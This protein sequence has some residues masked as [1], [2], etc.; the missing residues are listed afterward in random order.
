MRTPALWLALSAFLKGQC[1]L[2]EAAPVAA[3]APSGAARQLKQGVIRDVSEAD[4]ATWFGGALLKPPP[5]RRPLALRG[6][7]LTIPTPPPTP[8]PPTPLDAT[9]APAPNQVTHA[10]KLAASSALGG[11]K[12]RRRERLARG[13]RRSRRLR[14]RRT[15]RRQHRHR[16]GTAARQVASEASTPRKLR[17]SA[18]ELATVKLL[19]EQQAAAAKER[20]IQSEEAAKALSGMVSKAQEGM[21]IEQTRCDSHEEAG[22]TQLA[23]ARAGLVE[24][25]DRLFRLESSTEAAAGELAR[26]QERL[27]VE[28]WDLHA[29]VD[30]CRAGVWSLRHRLDELRK[31]SAS[32]GKAMQASPCQGG[33]AVVASLLGCGRSPTSLLSLNGR[34]GLRSLRAARSALRRAMARHTGHRQR[35]A[36]RLLRSSACVAAKRRGCKEVEEAMILM[37]AA[38][39]DEFAAAELELVGRERDCQ[40]VAN[41]YTHEMGDLVGRQA[42]LYQATAEASDRHAELMREV[43]LHREE[44]TKADSDH[45]EALRRCKRS[46]GGYNKQICRLQKMRT[47]IFKAT[48]AASVAADLRDCEVGAWVPEECSASCGGGERILRRRV[49]VQPGRLGMPCPNLTQRQTCNPQPCP[50]DCRVS[51]WGGWSA[52]SAPCSGG[53][54]TR[55]RSVLARAQGG[56]EP[57]PDENSISR[58]CNTQPCDADCAL[59]EWGGWSNCSRVCGGGFQ[60][61]IRDVATPA[62]GAGLCPTEAERLEYKHCNKQTCQTAASGQQLRCSTPMDVL[63]ILDG[64]TETHED[65]F[66]ASKRFLFGLIN[67]LDLGEQK[68]RLAVIVA[69]GPDTWENFNTCTQAEYVSAPEENCGVRLALPPT[70]L[71][72]TASMKVNSLTWPNS[73]A[74]YMAGGLALAKSVLVGQGRPGVPHVVLVISRGAPLSSTRTSEQAAE[75]RQRSRVFWLVAGSDVTPHQAAGWASKPARD[76]VF[77]VRDLPI[78]GNASAL[79]EVLPA[80]CPVLAPQ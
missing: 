6:L 2:S 60:T 3:A 29:E 62:V 9:R 25:Q 74:P 13:A 23:A 30:R 7:N 47:D 69:G 26:V 17:V 65:G 76:N 14:R 46:L 73:P 4:A 1:S 24:S 28:Q 67:S 36:G 80:L 56:G 12:L 71:G 22:R 57:C 52:C 48:G 33:A 18:R 34:H 38:V 31:D 5:R 19:R 66:E 44:L 54:M 78:L 68:T 70:G 41:G 27:Q 51:D 42:Q 21:E 32:I 45:A 20:R 59:T 11:T 35:V 8:A 10:V 55:S 75:L 53:V 16:G 43:H 15:M 58:Q 63:V 79:T 37:M 49:V 72:T 50:I 77:L 61:R 64:G 39:Q 40:R